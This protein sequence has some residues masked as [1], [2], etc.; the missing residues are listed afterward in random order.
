MRL[1]MKASSISSYVLLLCINQWMMKQPVHNRPYFINLAS[2][3]C[4]IE[5]FHICHWCLA[6]KLSQFWAEFIFP[7]FKRWQL[8]ICGPYSTANS[9]HLRINL[10]FFHFFFQLFC[11]FK[12]QG[13]LFF[14]S[15]SIFVPYHC[16]FSYCSLLFGFRFT[17]GNFI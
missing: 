5:W 10:L 16:V 11:L 12:K 7:L 9:T 2:C 13:N 8:Q 17:Q 4:N 6:N 1:L 14:L 15:L 3:K